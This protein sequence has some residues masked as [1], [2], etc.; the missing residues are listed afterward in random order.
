MKKPT[1][2]D[3]A[4]VAAY[5]RQL[6]KYP[7]PSVTADIIAVRPAY[8]ELGEGQWRENPEFTLEM[9]FIKRGQWPFEGCWA[10]PGGFIPTRQWMKGRAANCAR[11]PR[12]RPST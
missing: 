11:R 1:S 2:E 8:G 6:G 12:L 9:L 4:K 5:R 3:A 7:K 10:L